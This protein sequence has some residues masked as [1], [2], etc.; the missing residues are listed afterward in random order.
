MNSLSWLIYVGDVVSGISFTVGFMGFFAVV[1]GCACFISGLVR[2]RKW[3]WDSDEEYQQKK[4]AQKSVRSL[5][6]PLLIA[7]P[8]AFLVAS[9]IPSS[10]TI[11]MIAASEV[12]ETVVT[13]PE[14]LEI[15]G[16][17]KALIKKRLKDELAPE[18][19]ED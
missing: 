10:K 18:K 4:A 12:G 2:V 6:K 15:L 1:T 16:D 8:I 7:G 3:S 11:Y 13:S 17:V 14:S 5:A 19:P 9:F